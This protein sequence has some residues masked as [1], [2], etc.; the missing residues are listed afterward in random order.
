[1]PIYRVA[2]T[3]RPQQGIF[4]VVIIDEASQSGPEAAYLTY[5]GE[6]VVV[7]GDDKQI[8]PDNVGVNREDVH[9]LVEQYL[10]DIPN[11]EL[12]G[13]DNSFFD[14]AMVRY[15]GRIRLRE[16]FRCMPEIIQYSNNLC[17]MSEPLVP[18]R[19]Y[20]AGRL[21][22]VR[23]VYVMEGY[24][25]GLSANKINPPEADAVVETIAQ[26]CKDPRYDN[27]L[28][29]VISLLGD[30]QHREIERKLLER[31]GP[32]EMESRALVCGNPYA[33]QGDERDIIFL[34]MVSAPTGDTRLGTLTRESDKRRF[35]VAVS[36]AKDQVWLFHSAT[37]NDLSSRCL[38]YDLL[39]YCQ[40]PQVQ[41]VAAGANLVDLLRVSHAADRQV[42]RPPSPFDSWF[43][44][45]V[46]IQIANRGYRALP[47]FEVAEYRI[48]IVVEGMEGR[49]AVEC[50]GDRWHGAEQYER[51]V[52]R[53]MILERCGCTF[54]RVRESTFYREPEK[55]LES[56][57]TT[58][59]AMGIEPESRW[60]QKHRFSEEQQETDG[61]D[62]QTGD[63]TR[64]DEQ[65]GEAARE[66]NSETRS[67]AESRTERPAES[68]T[69]ETRDTAW[70]PKTDHVEVD[71]DVE[72]LVEHRCFGIGQVLDICGSGSE[73]KVTV[74]FEGIGIKKLALGLA[75]LKRAEAA[76][77]KN[78]AMR[79]PP[80]YEQLEPIAQKEYEAWKESPLPD[81]HTAK[82]AEVAERLLEIISAEG[83]MLVRRA[84]SLYSRAAGF[85]RAGKQI[86]DSL[87]GVLS[88][89][90][91][92]EE[93]M[94]RDEYG[95][96]DVETKVVRA[97]GTPEVVYRTRGD[98]DFSDIP[99]S[100]LATALKSIQANK[101]RL[102]EEDLYREVLSAYN[103]IRLTHS[104]REM[105]K[106]AARLTSFQ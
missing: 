9:Q 50:D 85:Q 2:E 53:Q 3:V 105:L 54:W 33:F 19:Q 47:Q 64:R 58:L 51:D 26:C 37:L 39:S 96:R 24:Q 28:M 106:R 30:Y 75:N 20:G 89:L 57:W 23:T 102:R 12:F 83:P 103:T 21:D 13:V 86:R 90:E 31:I 78:G 92:R 71:F 61:E 17:Y 25:T 18:L 65:R 76:A 60:K 62:E 43:E 45:D 99:L 68:S 36:R 72:D 15:G 59:L 27:K 73:A 6:K 104:V 4:D 94:L 56:L 70:A 77:P 67:G 52:G 101:K 34:S 1:M 93:V 10:G 32:E 48:D 55:A 38:R 95:S 42:D 66:N 98:R 91:R 82:S 44:V 41:T 22:P 63:H 81:P 40:N 16:H 5:L 46:F 100:E 79:S 87:K 29:G 97:S 8:S 35:N 11:C 69:V 74:R 84:I 80:G 14:I 7:V 49:L 88:R